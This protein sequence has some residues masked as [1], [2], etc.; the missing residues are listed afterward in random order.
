MVQVQIQPTMSPAAQQKI[1]GLGGA[2]AKTWEDRFT[3]TFDHLGERLAQTIR[4]TNYIATTS[5]AI[6]AAMASSAGAHGMSA[7]PAS[8]S[9]VARNP[10]DA[11]AMRANRN[12]EWLRISMDKLES[13]MSRVT[14][15]AALGVGIAG[16]I[17]GVE[18]FVG[19]VRDATS[20][21]SEL[22]IGFGELQKSLQDSSGKLTG[23]GGLMANLLGTTQKLGYSTFR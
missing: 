13:A 8:A 10:Q 6:S 17:T 18:A 21:A 9:F 1:V 3:A 4:G 12:L 16:G 20:A 15:G 19:G 11:L 7:V 5:A 23:P 2:T 22:K 14:K